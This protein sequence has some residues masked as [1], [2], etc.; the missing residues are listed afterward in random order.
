VD[1]LVQIWTSKRRAQMMYLAS[2][3]DIPLLII[4][5]DGTIREQQFV[6][7]RGEFTVVKSTY[8]ILEKD[9]VGSVDDLKP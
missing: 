9:R 1:S 5:F 2:P 7:T 8:I 3:D 4:K 6:N